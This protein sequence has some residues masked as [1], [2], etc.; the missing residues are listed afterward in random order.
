MPIL[1]V[2]GYAGGE[3]RSRIDREVPGAVVLRKPLQSEDLHG[4]VVRILSGAR[5][6]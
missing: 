6:Q 4:A 3:T 2:S 1:F 5:P